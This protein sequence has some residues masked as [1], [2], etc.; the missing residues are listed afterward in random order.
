MGE[1][2]DLRTSLLWQL[3]E[4]VSFEAVFRTERA[5]VGA[6]FL[7]LRMAHYNPTACNRIFTKFH[8]SMYEWL[9][10]SYNGDSETA[11][12]S[13]ANYKAVGWRYVSR[14]APRPFE[15]EEKHAI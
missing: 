13:R 3:E 15:R 4:S 5:R 11:K 1:H 6:K 14:R 10:T 7:A 8:F 2:A 9:E 12:R